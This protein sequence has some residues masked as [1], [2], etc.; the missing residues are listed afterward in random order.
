MNG[1]DISDPTRRFS[2]NEYQKLPQVVKNLISEKRKEALK[3]KGPT[4]VLAT[5]TGPEDEEETG[6]DSTPADSFGKSSYNN[7]ANNNKHGKSVKSKKSKKVSK[8]YTSQR[9]IIASTQ[10]TTNN[11][12]HCNIKSS[13][14]EN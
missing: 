4:R 11:N 2:H 14:Y 13:Y 6:S 3:T 9:R 1:V 5:S 7:N 10:G 8:V 12:P